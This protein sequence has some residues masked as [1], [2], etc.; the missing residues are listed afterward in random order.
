MYYIFPVRRNSVYFY[1]QLENENLLK[2]LFRSQG[3]KIL[4]K[5]PILSRFHSSWDLKRTKS[6]SRNTQASSVDN[7][8][9]TLFPY[10]FIFW[11]TTR[12]F[13]ISYNFSFCEY[14][15]FILLRFEDFSC[16]AVYLPRHPHV[17]TYHDYT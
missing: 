8:L 16:K 7:C 9:V 17:L 6:S 1:C 2:I 3:K 14:P 12:T 11:L 10:C 13:L 4:Q 5:Y 15:C